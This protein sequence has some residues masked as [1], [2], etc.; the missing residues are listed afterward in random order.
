MLRD[1]AHGLILAGR[2]PFDLASA[3]MKECEAELKRLEKR[4]ERKA[5]RGRGQGRLEDVLW[6]LKENDMQKLVEILR[7]YPGISHASLSVSG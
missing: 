5:K 7:R 6:L 1:S 2:E 4:L 3:D